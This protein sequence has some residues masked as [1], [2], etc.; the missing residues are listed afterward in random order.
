MI[1]RLEELCDDENATKAS[2]EVAQFEFGEPTK[3]EKPPAG[4]DEPGLTLTIADCQEP[5]VVLARTQVDE[6][7]VK[8]VA[9]RL[10][11]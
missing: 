4:F 8:L 3:T 11:N 6:L 1:I 2:L 10:A 5:F 7:I 9:W